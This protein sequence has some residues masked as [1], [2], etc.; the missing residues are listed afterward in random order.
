[1][2]QDSAAMLGR[3]ALRRVPAAPAPATPPHGRPGGR[4]RAA[5]ELVEADLRAVRAALVAVATYVADVEAALSEAAPTPERLEGL[6]LGD[7][8]DEPL[9]ELSTVLWSLRRRLARVAARG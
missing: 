2:K 8:A 7:G 5:L 1:M 3:V 6:A 9:D 4:E